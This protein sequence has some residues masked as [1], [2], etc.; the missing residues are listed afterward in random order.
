MLKLNEI[1]KKYR[2]YKKSV[3]DSNVNEHYYKMVLSDIHINVNKILNEL[4]KNYDIDSS[5]LYDSHNSLSLKVNNINEDKIEEAKDFL[6]ENLP[7][8]KKLSYY[9]DDKRLVLN[10]I[11]VSDSIKFKFN[12]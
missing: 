11:D 3:I 10:F 5:F 7:Y 6:Y 2:D 12:I 8:F 4:D 1:M 9:D